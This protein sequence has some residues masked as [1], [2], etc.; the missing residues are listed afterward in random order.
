[1]CVTL[2]SGEIE[3]G[4]LTSAM[5]VTR[6]PLNSRWSSFS[7]AVLRSL[8]VSNS[9]NLYGP[10]QFGELLRGKGSQAWLG[11]ANGKPT[12]FL[13]HGQFPNKRHPVQTVERSLSGPIEW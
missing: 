11:D 7:T 5:Q 1:M 9:T 4:L 13:V 8:A 3:I 2:E 12:L 6:E 10:C